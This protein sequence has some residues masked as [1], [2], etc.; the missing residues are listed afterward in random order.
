MERRLPSIL[1]V[2]LCAVTAQGQPSEP[3]VLDALEQWGQWRGPLGTGEAPKA[4]PPLEWSEKKNLQWK[5]PIPGHGHASP[6]VWGDKVFV[7]SAV[8]HGEKLAVPEQPAGAHNNLDPEKMTRFIAMA[9]DRKTGKPLWQ[10]TLRNAQPHQS[11]HESGTWASAS[12]VTD[13]ERLYAFFGSNGLYCLSTKGEL[14]WEKDFGDMLVK[15]GHGEGASP[16]LHEDTLVV[17][18]DHE[19]DS[20]IVALDAKTGKELWRQARDEVTSWATPLIVKVDGK[21]QVIVSGSTALRGYD[22]ATGKI[23]WSCGGLSNNVV[24]SPVAADGILI[25]GSSYVRQTM[26]SIRLSGA[27]GDLSGSDNV[28]WARRQRTPY[29][30]SP[31]LYRGHVY[32]LR[33]YQAILSRLDA[34]TGNEPSGPFRLPG[35]LNLYASPVVA[36]GRIYLTD[37]TGAT[38]VLDDGA[39]PRVLALNKL[40]E[41]INASAAIAGQRIFLRGS[42]H[43]Y[44]LGED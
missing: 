27:K 1:A 28:L 2:A 18:W 17:N 19:G 40:D 33:H 24:A 43:L 7:I 3:P 12:P 14:L 10:K 39:E 41:A 38:L 29:V 26:L 35:L 4:T 8:A 5:T 42:H 20:F 16:A 32:F 6:I 21:P 23:L 44:C 25:A 34:K 9:L 30:P 31:M 22:L 11:A 13:G 15:H 36:K 37:Q